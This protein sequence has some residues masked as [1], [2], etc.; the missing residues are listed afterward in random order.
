MIWLCQV[1]VA[2]CG[3]FSCG[4]RT[5]SHGLWDLV[6]WPGLKPRPPAQGT[7]SASHW[8][9]RGSLNTKVFKH[10]SKISCSPHSKEDNLLLKKDSAPF[11]ARR[12]LWESLP[13]CI[14]VHKT[15]YDYNHSLSEIWRKRSFNLLTHNHLYRR[16]NRTKNTRLH[17][18]KRRCF[19]KL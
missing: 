8:T 11:L 4:T 5:L 19:V 1:L 12:H 10:S 18:S 16:K 6:P 2:A 7:R 17:H 3:T 15:V 14:C 9:T 13:T